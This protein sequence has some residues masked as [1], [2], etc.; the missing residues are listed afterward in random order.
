MKKYVWWGI[1]PA[2]LISTLSAIICQHFPFFEIKERIFVTFLTFLLLYSYFAIKAVN[3]ATQ[4]YESLRKK[5]ETLKIEKRGMIPVFP[6]LKLDSL[7]YCQQQIKKMEKAKEGLQKEY[8]NLQKRINTYEF[9]KSQTSELPKIFKLFSEHLNLIIKITEDDALKI[10]KQVEDLYNDNVKILDLIKKS[11][12]SGQK[13]IEVIS[14]QLEHNEKIINVLEN[15]TY[16]QKTKLQDNFARVAGLVEGIKEFIIFVDDIKEI[17]K[18]TNILSINAAIEA[19]HAK[20]YGKSFAVVAEEVRRLAIRTEEISRQIIEQM[21]KLLEKADEEFQ[22]FQRQLLK[23]ED[24][25][26]LEQ[27][28]KMVKDIEAKFKEVGHIMIDLI[29]KIQDQQQLVVDIITD[30]LGRIQFQDVVRQKLERVIEGLEELSGYLTSL[31]KWLEWPDT[32]EKPLEIQKILES[33]YQ[34]YVTVSQ[35]EVHERVINKNIVKRKEAPKIE[36]F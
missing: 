12:Y 23:S 5:Y 34:K 30:L 13:L 15:L 14:N 22:E 32:E 28:E 20:G 36:L 25:E 26:K 8:E 16:S 10:T 9:L 35:R 11:V 17:A 3:S 24:L 31:M 19:A 7:A 4:N 21:E 6:L 29:N 2:F 33:F 18:Q 27:A 1:V